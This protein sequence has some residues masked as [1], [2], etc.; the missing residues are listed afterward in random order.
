MY[1]SPQPSAVYHISG[2]PPV[3]E[4]Y[5]IS[6]YD[7]FASE[8]AK[9][10]HARVTIRQVQSGKMEDA[11]Q[12]YLNS[13][14]SLRRQQSSI[15]AILLT[16]RDTGNVVNITLWKSRDVAARSAGGLPVSPIS[17]V[18]NSVNAAQMAS[19]ADTPASVLND[20]VRRIF[21]S[22]RRGP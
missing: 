15:V 18:L 19:D 13:A 3:R 21:H 12:V 7:C 17:L 11:I 1:A 16:D 9:A 6:V 22:L 10:T 2:G 14:V 5:E 8:L 4:V 20:A